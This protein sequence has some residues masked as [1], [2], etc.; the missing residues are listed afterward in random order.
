MRTFFTSACIITI[1]RN[2]F[3]LPQKSCLT[4]SFSSKA[5]IPKKIKPTIKV[6][7]GLRIQQ[8]YPKSHAG[9]KLQ[10]ETQMLQPIHVDL[11]RR[12]LFS[13]PLHS[14][15]LAKNPL[16]KVISLHGPR[17]QVL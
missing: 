17:A 6:I 13:F 15:R 7:V 5:T 12:N 10:Q 16:F 2:P 3:Y 8:P 11:R 1:S 14:K 4:Y 9:V